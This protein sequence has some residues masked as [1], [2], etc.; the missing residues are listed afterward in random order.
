MTRIIEHIERLLYIHDCVIVPEFGGFV[1]QVVPAV[2]E[3]TDHAFRPVRKEI[4]FNPT[5]KHND[6]LLSESY[7]KDFGINFKD[8]QRMLKEDVDAL[9]AT[10]DQRNKLS[11]GNIGI[12]HKE[13]EGTLHFQPQDGAQFSIESYGLDSF[14]LLPLQSIIEE[15]EKTV[16][17]IAS[18]KRN[19]KDVYYIPVSRIFLR[20][21]GASVAAVLLFFILSTPVKDVNHAT[22]T[23]SFAPAEMTVPTT[24]KEVKEVE[25]VVSA[26]IK[27]EETK[28]E[29]V[30]SSTAPE[31]HAAEV[32]A[33]PVEK[34]QIASVKEET[35]NTDKKYY[36]VIA[37]FDTE[38]QAKKYLSEKKFP[39]GFK[40]GMVKRGEKVRVYTDQFTDRGKAESSL[41]ALRSDSHYASAWLFISR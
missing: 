36:L 25:P 6:G 15:R 4:V 27:G 37:S 16:K 21:A 1:L 22:Y 5:L 9:K 29:T 8:A 34:K 19:R 23:A 12:F 11:F 31:Q 40:V 2:C 24:K 7:M 32:S 33:R 14:H 38:S 35:A 28:P 20:V 17:L 30:E 26:D 3:D 41:A 13:K 39:S 10:L 18:S